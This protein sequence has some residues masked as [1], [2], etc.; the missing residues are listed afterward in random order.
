MNEL[1]ITISEFAKLTGLSR[2]ALLIYE[3]IGLLLPKSR[4]DKNYRKYN[5][6]QATTANEITTL[7]GLGFSLEEIKRIFILKGG[8]KESIISILK[9]QK[10]RIRENIKN[11]QR[12]IKEIESLI[13][14]KNKIQFKSEQ[15]SIIL[16]ALSDQITNLDKDA[17]SECTKNIPSED[18]IMTVA[19]VDQ[20]AR[21][22]LFSILSDKAKK[23]V[24]ND[25]NKLIKKY[26]DHWS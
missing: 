15:K 6:S 13:S 21:D 18:Y 9:A 10:T 3:D 12:Q 8:E 4:T 11:E 24:K 23:L 19:M 1:L 25:L 22:N 5:P 2:K 16:K 14:G 26:S 20:N 7:K 17:I